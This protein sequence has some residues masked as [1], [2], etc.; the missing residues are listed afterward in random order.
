MPLVRTDDPATTPLRTTDPGADT[1]AR[2][3]A[4]LDLLAAEGG[5]VTGEALAERFGVSRQA[6]VHDVAI[7]RAAGEPIVATVRGYLLAPAAGRLACRT[8][9]AVRHRPDV[10]E[11]ELLALVDLGIRVID[12]TVEHP[13]YG[14][15]RGELHLASPADVRAWAQATRRSGVHLLSELTDG[16]HLHTLEAP[17]EELLGRAR[18]VLAERGYLLDDDQLDDDQDDRLAEN[19]EGTR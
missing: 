19:S 18:A 12:V 1:P 15:L 8:V 11:D 9:V 10:A 2:R 7:L 13:L 6:I 14:E 4:L 16:V 3:R 5:P 17:S